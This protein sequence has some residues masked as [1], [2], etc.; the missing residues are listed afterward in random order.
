PH[1]RRAAAALP[2]RERVA[3]SAGA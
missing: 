2:A 3:G 1:T